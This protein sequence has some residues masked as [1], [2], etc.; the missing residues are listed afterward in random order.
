MYERAVALAKEAKTRSQASKGFDVVW[1][2]RGHCI[3]SADTYGDACMIQ[4][5]FSSQDD[6][7]DTVLEMAS[8]LE[9]LR[10]KGV[11]VG[12][13]KESGKEPYLAYVI[14]PESELSDDETMRRLF[15]AESRIKEL[16]EDA[17]SILN[18]QEQQSEKIAEL[19]A[20]LSVAEAAKDLLRKEA[21]GL[22]CRVEKLEAE[23]ARLREQA[24]NRLVG[25]CNRCGQW[26]YLRDARYAG[27]SSL[28]CRECFAIG[29]REP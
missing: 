19:E 16:E 5:I 20:G 21:K 11:T 14:E 4:D 22:A 27:D 29:K 15:D 7:A 12:V 26:V 8:K 18:L 2:A 6:L 1:N 9:F 3:V 17:R 28:Y 10:S 13:V 24:A 25:L 23:N